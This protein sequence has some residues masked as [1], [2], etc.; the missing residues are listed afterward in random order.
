MTRY[1][2]A[3]NTVKTK[4]NE[5]QSS[6]QCHATQA[7]YVLDFAA[8]RASCMVPKLL[9]HRFTFLVLV[10]RPCGELGK[11]GPANEICG[12]LITPR[13]GHWLSL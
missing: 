5:T 13:L 6:L 1:R 4:T 12:W 9:L 3:K 8:H 11:R 7:D 10:C 2:Q